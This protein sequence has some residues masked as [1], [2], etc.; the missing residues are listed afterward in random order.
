[1]PKLLTPAEAAEFLGISTKTLSNWRWCRCGP[2]FL[3][4]G[5]RIL[6]DPRH[7]DNWLEEVAVNT[8]PSTARAKSPG[9][10]L[11]KAPIQKGAQA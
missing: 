1:M 2:R 7:L 5:R 4:L 11:P 9:G 6:Y 3:R 10:A 8:H